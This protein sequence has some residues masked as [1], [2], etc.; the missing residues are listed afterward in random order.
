MKF[1]KM[2]GTGNDY[3]YVNT[4]KEKVTDP[5]SLSRA[6]SRPHFGIGSD[7]LILI[8]SASEESGADFSMDIYNA[9][10]SRAKMCG[11]GIR[12]VGKYVYDHGLT[13]QT[14]VKIDTLS[15]VKTLKLKLRDAGEH[16]RISNQGKVVESATVDMGSPILTPEKVPVALP[17]DS[18]ATRIHEIMGNKYQGMEELAAVKVP[19]VINDTVYYGTAVSMGN[20]HFV[21]FVSD[22]KEFPLEDVGP[23][24]ELNRMFPDHVNA[25][26][27]E[28]L[29]PDLIR[30][31]VWERGSGE[32][33]ACGTGACAT[34]VAAVLNGKAAPDTEIELQLAGG[35][36]KVKWDLEKNT[37]FMTG[38]AETVFEGEWF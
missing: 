11:N 22:V 12:C 37:V 28:V 20:P 23:L 31:R 25:E 8:G 34:A 4:M 26:F 9:D 18:T 5:E 29:A 35:K 33:L 36:L 2:H 14:T 15:G 16:D 24:V 3:V 19:L 21:T 7:G 1:T 6:V 27:A 10:G 30:M 38:P 32:T 17:K 13:D